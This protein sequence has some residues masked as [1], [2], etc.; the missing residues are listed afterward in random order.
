MHVHIR[1]NFGCSTQKSCLQ[2]VEGKLCSKI[3]EDWSKIV[4]TILFTKL[5]TLPDLAVSNYISSLALWFVD[6]HRR[7]LERRYVYRNSS[8]WW[9][10][11][12]RSCRPLLLRYPIHLRKLYL[13]TVYDFA[14]E[15]VD[16]LV[17]LLH[18]MLC[19]CQT[20]K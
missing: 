19:F 7:R 3:S 13:F 17:S 9:R 18:W 11:V 14:N 15:V 1:F 16:S 10:V 4:V 20:L 8:L 5:N 6:S 12:S 2:N